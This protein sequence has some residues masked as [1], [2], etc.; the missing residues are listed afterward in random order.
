MDSNPQIADGTAEGT[1][2]N[3]ERSEI[4]VTPPAIPANTLLSPIPEVVLG[5][6]ERWVEDLKP[7]PLSL[8]IYGEERTDGLL[9][10]VSDNGII[11]PLL[12]TRSN[13]IISGHI[14]WRAA[15]EV[16]ARARKL[17]KARL[18][19][20]LLGKGL[21]G[22]NL[23]VELDVLMHRERSKRLEIEKVPVTV[24]PVEAPT[25]IELLLL[26]CNRQR[27]KTTEQR[28]R[29]FERYL[30][31][32]EP[33]AKKRQG[34]RSDLRTDSSASPIGRAREFAAKRVNLSATT[35]VKGSKVLQ[36]IR[37]HSDEA[38][39]DSAEKIRN[40]LNAKSIK[41]AYDEAVESGWIEP[42][43]EKPEQKTGGSA[44]GAAAGGQAA[45]Q[46][47][48]A[49]ES[50]EAPEPDVEG[51]SDAGSEPEYEG[52]AEAEK[53]PNGDASVKEIPTL[54]DESP[55]IPEIQSE[56]RNTV[57]SAL[58]KLD[59]GT[60]Q[61]FHTKLEEFIRNFMENLQGEASHE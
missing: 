19:Q 44:N 14:R 34:Q 52:D 35:A 45:P 51:A 25:E 12:I 43:K 23:K 47:I 4:A 24:S 8:A 39:R 10:S 9:E 57:M 58:K 20:E 56:I 21:S 15:Q 13:D 49:E 42:K 37:E 53:D 18:E 60:L 26:D 30:K 61:R 55:S 22:K 17:T 29:E 50:N 11:E 59:V 7:H 38:Q 31:L 27:T 2:E 32:E 5:D 40:L 33:A 48:V 54:P 1:N 46:V 36:A 6:G 41:A 16:I 3:S 28:L